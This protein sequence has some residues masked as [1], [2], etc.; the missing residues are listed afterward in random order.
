MSKINATFDINSKE[1]TIEATDPSPVHT[2][3][4]II[5]T[6]EEELIK[7]NNLSF[8]F[9][10]TNNDVLVFDKFFPTY[11]VRY[12][13]TVKDSV[14]ESAGWPCV[15]EA[16]YVIDLWLENNEERIET[17]YTCTTP[18]PIATFPSWTWDVEAKTW[19]PP[20]PHP[21]GVPKQWNEELG[22]WEEITAE[23]PPGSPVLPMPP[24]R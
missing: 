7:F 23:I 11:G 8:G 1:W 17:S 2:D 16:N 15:P 6:A 21:E 3:L 12:E 22:N 18:R 14:F 13:E 10:V 9:K 24:V 20:I 19:V 5:F 4:N